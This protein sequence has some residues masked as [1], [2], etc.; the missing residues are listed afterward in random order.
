M[1]EICENLHRLFQRLLTFSFPFDS[2]KLPRNGIYI[3][4]ELGESAHETGRIVRIGTHTGD[5]QLPSRLKEHFLKENKDRSIFRKNIGRAIL[6]KTNDPFLAQWNIDL[7]TRQARITHSGK[8]NRARLQAVEKQVTDYIQR[9][10]RFAVFRVDDIK[11]RLSL[12]SG[13]I[14]TISLCDRCQ[15]SDNWLGLHSPI[16]KIRQSGLW[17]VNELYKKPLSAEEF[18]E[19][20][21]LVIS[22]C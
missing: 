3:L 6:K 22:S 9:N 4:Y 21:H 18:D 17:L 7:T 11:K 10:F 12:E 14:S 5:N 13:I 15:R 16:E 1:S 20:Q 8:I 19:L 2:N